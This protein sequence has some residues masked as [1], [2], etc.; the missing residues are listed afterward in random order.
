[1]AENLFTTLQRHTGRLVLGVLAVTALLVVPFLAMAPTESAST[2]PGGPVFDARDRIDERFV[3]SVFFTGFIAEPN[4][5][6]LLLVE[7][8]QELL[9]AEDA[10]RA[11]PTLGPALFEYY[12]VDAA[13]EVTGVLTIA[14]LIDAE[15][16]PTGG[17]ATATDAQV[18]AAGALLI[19]ELGV[20]SDVLGLSQQTTRNADGD[21]VVPAAFIAVL[22]DDTQLGFGNVSVNLGGDTASEQYS[23]DI[24]DVIRTADNWTIN[25]VA[26]DVNL[27]SEEQGAVAGPFIGFTVLA[28]LL[29]VGFTF[30]S[31]WVLA[32]VSAA[33]LILLIWLKGITNL[34][35]FEDDLILSLIV[36]IAMVSFGVDYA[37]HAIGRYREERHE[38]R[39]AAP[40]AIAGG[41]AVSGALV[42]ATVSDS[43]AFLA[44]V[45]AGIES[46]VQFGIGA[47]IALFSAFLLLGV[48][49]PF[50]I[51]AIEARVPAPQAGR[52]STALRVFGALGAASLAM[53]SVLMLVFVLPWLGVVLTV[54]TIAATLVGP[55]LIARRREG[56]RV[57]DLPVAGGEAGLGK[58]IGSVVAAIASRPR[59]VLPVALGITIIASFFAVQV[60]ARFDVEDFFSADTDFVQGLDM[61]DEHIGQRDGEPGTI[62][63]E[64]DLTDPANLAT[65]QARLDELRTSGTEALAL[66]SAGEVR[67]IEAGVFDVFEQTWASP[68]MAGIV[69]EQTGVEITDV[70]GDALPD[71]RAQVEALLAVASTVGVPLD[72][73]RLA[74]TP[75]DVAVRVDLSDSGPDATQIVFA[76]PNSRDQGAVRDARAILDAT[77]DAIS[78]DLGGTFV[79]AT[80]SPIVREASLE[81]TN[82]ALLVSLPI[83][84]LACL[85][86]ASTFLRSIR[87]GLASVVPI[88]MVVAWLYAFMETAGYSI[89]LVT[90]TIAAVSIG[91]GIDFALHYISRYREELARWGQRSVAVRIAG[92]GTGLALVASA[93]SSAVGFGILAF[94]PMPLFAA[95]GL[96]TAIMI[97]MALVATLAVLPSLLV[98]ISSDE[99]ADISD[100]PL[101]LGGASGLDAAPAL[102]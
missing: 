4:G 21:W 56:V 93:V 95:Y 99:Q 67:F 34:I 9:A 24:Q 11:D 26:I 84:V 13:A 16:A 25:G 70:N 76:V 75:D 17:L 3:G 7:P 44:N 47:A 58:R 62:Y 83:A 72:A 74:L 87:Y 32:V 82:R 100:L 85:A 23:R 52:R 63:I 54:V 97:L 42:L 98:L 22:S 101:D 20:D 46:V 33:F 1:M 61:I 94:A 91:I 88:L 68:I 14:D 64:G 28:A 6:D 51:A 53:A 5:G 19:D 60:P 18:K 40:A 27:T 77:A 31:Y 43:V 66:D 92:E 36:P 102:V 71:D 69:A 81:G 65:V 29:L 37:F 59:V 96:L 15:V 41:A 10:L 57:G 12:E 55:V 38:G 45:T 48:V 39:S 35:G 90:A 50:V 79:Q 80:G 78:E 30:R 86:V 89:N 8:L 73:E 2:E 49:A